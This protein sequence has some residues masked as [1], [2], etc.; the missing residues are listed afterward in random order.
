MAPREAT[1]A[2]A[3]QYLSI[4]HYEQHAFNTAN[5]LPPTPL[6]HNDTG[7]DDEGSSVSFMDGGDAANG[8]EFHMAMGGTA[9]VVHHAHAHTHHH[10]G[11]DEAMHHAVDHAVEPGSP[12]TGPNVDPLS[13]DPTMTEGALGDDSLFRHPQRRRVGEAFDIMSSPG[14][15]TT[16]TNEG[17][18]PRN[19]MVGNHPPPYGVLRTV[20]ANNLG[21]GVPRLISTPGSP[22][23][24]DSATTVP[25]LDATMDASF[26]TDSESVAYHSAVQSPPHPPRHHHHDIQHRN[27][28]TIPRGNIPPPPILRFCPRTTTITDLKYFA[29]RGCIVPLLAALETPRL[30]ALGAR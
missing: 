27:L 20:S 30:V 3:D 23:T 29:E 14:A 15:A 11:D 13:I 1:N 6:P 21:A 8:E 5:Q 28:R 24:N 4:E 17:T 22:D 2:Y 26:D 7:D 16:V 19:N 10:Q 12:A 18:P 25:D 9:A